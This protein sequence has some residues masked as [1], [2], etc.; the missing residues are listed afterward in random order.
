MTATER[1]FQ[2]ILKEWDN[3]QAAIHKPADAKFMIR[4]WAITLY[5]AFFG[6][7]IYQNNRAMISIAIG[8]TLLFRLLDALAR[9]I[10]GSS[11]T[12]LLGSIVLLSLMSL[13]LF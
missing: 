11:R 12:L 2:I 3:A 9:I 4:R 5:S 1:T 13:L 6:L 10:F 8:A 7:S